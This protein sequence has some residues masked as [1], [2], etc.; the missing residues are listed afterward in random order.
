MSEV[1][2]TLPFKSITTEQ[3]L[4]D[5]IIIPFSKKIVILKLPSF[6]A[7]VNVDDIMKIDYSNIIG[8]LITFPVILNRIG[9]LRAEMEEIAKNKKFEAQVYEAQLKQH[10]RNKGITRTG[11]GERKKPTI[12]EVEEAVLMDKGYQVVMRNLY[13]TEKGFTQVENLFW[14]AKDKSAKLDAITNKLNPEEFEKEIIE[15][16]VNGIMIKIK[17]SKW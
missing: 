2:Y 4:D 11:E 16:Q 1:K 8:E 13:N 9:L 3:V 12:S 17:K 10:Y 6:D 15:G 7:E 14:S 5:K